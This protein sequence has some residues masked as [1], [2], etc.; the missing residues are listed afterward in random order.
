MDWGQAL[1]DVNWWAVLAAALSSFAVGALWYGRALFGKSWM[2]LA[3]VSEESINA[4]KEM[5]G[6]G[7]PTSSYL[8]TAVTAV[9]TAILL[10]V[11]LIA[12]GTTGFF[13]AALLGA[14]L[15]LVFRLGAHVI[16][17]GFA[18][19][20]LALTGIDGLHDVVAM[21]VAAGILGAWV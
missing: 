10:A 8:M 2:R 17:N 6:S 19:R 13:P 12:T 21:A 9:A 7:G 11:L 3:G 16:H 14:V 18:G 1:G 15:G 4:R 20:P 5:G